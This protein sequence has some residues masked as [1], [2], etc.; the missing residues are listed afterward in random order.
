MSKQ[1]MG[2]QAEVKQLLKLVINSL[3]SHKDI[4]LRE[5]ISISADAC[6]KL[7][8]E[9]LSNDKL[10][11]DDA[12]LKINI[13]SDQKTL[14]IEDNGIGMNRDEI[15]DNIGTIAKSGTKSFF[16]KL[17]GDQKQDS[18]LI[19]QF[20]VGF[21][22]AFIVAE[23]VTVESRR[24]GEDKDKGVRW[25]SQGEGDYTLEEINKPSRGTKVILDLRK[26]DLEFVENFR[27]KDLIHK[28]SEHIN[29]PIMLL[30]EVSSEDDK[31][32]EK[33]SV[34]EWQQINKATALWQLP[35]TGI[36]DE[37]YQEFYKTIAHDWENP[38]KWV[39]SKV[40][41]NLEY[42]QLLYIPSHA[43]F[44][45]YER[46]RTQGIKLYVKRVFIMEDTEKLMPNYL[47]FIRGII[48]S[49]DL[50]LNVSREILQSSK[51]INQINKGSVKKVLTMLENMA[52]NE[53]EEY[54]KFW[55]AFGQVF[56]EGIV[57][58]MNNKERISKLCRF[59]TSKGDEKQTVSLE[60]YVANM[61]EGQD[62]I[63]Y[64]T[65]ESYKAAKS[66]PHLEM[67]NKKGI[68]VILL[69]ER[70][71]EWLVSHLNE[72]DGKPLQS[73]TRSELDID[74]FSEEKDA[75]KKPETKVN[76]ELIKK[77]KKSLG[78][79]VEDIIISKR[80]TDSPACLVA[81][82]GA[83]DINMQRMM[84]SMGQDVPE[85]KRI[86]EINPN[87]PLLKHLKKEK[88]QTLFDDWSEVLLDQSVLAEGGHLSDPASFTSKLNSLLLALAK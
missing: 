20:G 66:S 80:L 3:Y 62:K 65:S 48:D 87:H 26:D 25:Q 37:E 9:A 56:K 1:T 45:L 50:P 85:S 54:Q 16:E 22:S 82:A 47:R 52:K 28:Y 35:R 34:L 10:F 11:E 53:T 23:K 61:K 69:F 84:K 60:Q 86:L 36:K 67:L 46:E 24:A 38:M 27:I 6:D 78:D 41:G 40:E 68:E 32:K 7:R 51:V 17:T 33:E 70:I 77:I 39:H 88:D 4:F 13:S 30:E 55:D 58:D 12:Q 5:L 76:K 19:G 43:P 29:I 21:Y 73:V 72:F 14:T 18:N 79:K 49:N 63:Y 31:N 15:I 75:K 2:F 83:M 8:F 64:I 81:G 59:S 57:E 71:D 44:D 74:K 42:T